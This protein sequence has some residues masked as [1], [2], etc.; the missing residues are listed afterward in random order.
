MACSR[1][2]N[3]VRSASNSTVAVPPTRSTRALDTPGL[4]ESFRSTVGIKLDRRRASRQVHTRAR[5]AGTGREFPFDATGAIAARHAAHRN[6]DS[7]EAHILMM[8]RKPGRWRER[9]EPPY[10]VIGRVP[11]AIS[12][13][14]P[15]RTVGS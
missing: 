12:T 7:L 3:L 2:G 14:S 8:H 5:Y 15:G 6:F 11:S 10:D 4:V 13:N 9:T 1:S